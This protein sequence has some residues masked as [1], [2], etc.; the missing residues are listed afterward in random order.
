MSQVQIWKNR[1]QKPINLSLLQPL[2]AKPNAKRLRGRIWVAEVA[3]SAYSRE[4]GA[5]DA[6]KYA[7]AE[8][9]AVLDFD[10]ERGAVEQAGRLDCLT[11]VG[12]GAA[13]EGE[14]GWVGSRAVEA[15]D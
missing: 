9:L 8:G 14:E 1:L 5:F 4:A 11:R 3:V 7:L 13:G 6:E 12:D 15:G 2:V 10:A